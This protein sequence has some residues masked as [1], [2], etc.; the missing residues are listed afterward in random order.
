MVQNFTNTDK[1][2]R[3]ILIP[4]PNRRVT[5]INNIKNPPAQAMMPMSRGTL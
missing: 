3:V 1:K 2:P 4:G 5:H